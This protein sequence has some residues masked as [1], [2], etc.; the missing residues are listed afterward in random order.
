MSVIA[1]PDV[2]NP[3]TNLGFTLVGATLLHV[4]LILGT[5]FSMPRPQHDDQLPE[6][7]ITLVQSHRPS[8]PDRAD[9][10]ANVSQEGGGES[11][12]PD[13]ATSPEQVVIPSPVA[14]TPREAQAPAEA[15]EQHRPPPRELLLDDKSDPMDLEVKAEPEK[16]PTPKVELKRGIRQSVNT[17]ELREQLMA[18]IAEEHQAYQKR[19]RRKFLSASTREYKYAAYMDAWRTKVERIGNLNYPEEA[20]QRN[21]TGSLVLDVAIRPDGTIDNINVIR[22]S[23]QQVLDDAAI[24]IVRLAAPYS[25]FPQNFRDDVDILHITRTWKFLH[26][27]RLQSQ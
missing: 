12:R 16:R 22:S 24:R 9:Y 18:A 20:K 17:Q 3:L 10:L 26:G 5:G 23:R 6:L 14:K 11:P 7:E 8:E 1:Y 25:P 15:I 27:A 2:D 13:L 4:V 19:P 21:L